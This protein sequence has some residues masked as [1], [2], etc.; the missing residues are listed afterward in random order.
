MDL[1]YKGTRYHG[2]Q[3]QENANTVQAELN[4]AL[5]LLLDEE[6]ETTGCGRTDAGVHARAY[7][8]HFDCAE[9]ADTQ[10]LTHKLN[11]ILPHDIAIAELTETKP[12]FHARFDAV[13]RTYKYFIHSRKSAFFD[14]FS[15]FFPR[16]LDIDAMNE[17]ATEMIG[18]HDF[19]SFCKVHSGAKTGICTLRSAKWT[20]Q[21]D[22]L[23]FTVS[24]DRFLR[25]MVRATVGTLLDAGLGK[26]NRKDFL[27]ILKAGD[28]RKAGVSVPAKG[29]FLWEV[30]YS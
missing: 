24:A 25:N 19:S 22:K 14:E 6:I 26:I 5:S 29:L 17:T 18:T 12:E 9:I 8:T 10:H 16:R 30:K 4:R 20:N 7:T 3:L 21:D 23:I 2:W 11:G 15:Y 27:E 1:S 13:E 28:R